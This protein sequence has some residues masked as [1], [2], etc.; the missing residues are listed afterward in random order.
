MSSTLDAIIAT[1]SRFLQR[2]PV[3]PIFFFRVM[4]SE[5]ECEGYHTICRRV[6]H[7]GASPEKAETIGHVYTPRSHFVHSSIELECGGMVVGSRLGDTTIFRWLSPYQQQTVVVVKFARIR[8]W[9][10]ALCFY[11]YE[12]CVFYFDNRSSAPLALAK[13]A[14]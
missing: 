3:I 7:V 6:W 13:K 1:I 11:R 4:L 8:F 10:A 5:F 14:S 12:T 2:Q 9:A